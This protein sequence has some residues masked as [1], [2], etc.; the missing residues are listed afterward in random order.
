MVFFLVLISVPYQPVLAAM[1]STDE[2]VSS[3]RAAEAR[4]YINAVLARQEIQDALINKGIDPAEAQ[5]RIDSLTDTEVIRLADRI[6]SVPAGGDAFSVLIGA[7]LVAF[8][9][10]I[11]T[12]ALGITDVF[13]FVKG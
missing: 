4:E 6:D 1:I 2:M 9:V 8:I 11:I 3:Q 12:D 13:P 5:A 7:A 10:L